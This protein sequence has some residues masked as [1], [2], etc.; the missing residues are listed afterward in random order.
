MLFLDSYK[1]QC[2]PN[3]NTHEKRLQ[4]R[5][6][7][8]SF[9]KFLRSLFFLNTTGWLLLQ[10]ACNNAENV[11]ILFWTNMISKF[12]IYPESNVS[13]LDIDIYKIE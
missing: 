3:W 13:V 1:T 5:F 10:L 11:A 9:A 12:N 2:P 6:F 4:D 7:P 8:A